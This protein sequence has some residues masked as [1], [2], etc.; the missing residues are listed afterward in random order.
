MADKTTDSTDEEVLEDEEQEEVDPAQAEDE[1]DDSTDTDT[2]DSDEEET[3]ETDED[4][5]ESDKEESEDFTK[6]FTQFKGDDPQEYLKNLEDGYAESSKEAVRL[7]RENR[8]LKANLNK[9]IATEPDLTKSD[10]G[11]GMPA[12]PVAK[13]PAL[14]W[15]EARM[16]ETNTREYNEFAEKHPEILTDPKLVEELDDE[17]AVIGAAY[18]QRHGSPISLGVGLEKAWVTLGKD[19]SDKQEQVASA[20][21]ASAG[22]SKASGGNTSKAPKSKFSE[23]QITVAMDMM[24][25]DRET[26]IKNLSAYA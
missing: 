19:T 18:F 1:T 23:Q 11:E 7:S 12:D 6:R 4:D 26:A 24:N 13:D 2:D 17:L 22:Q 15:A 14:A 20:A 16:K 9:L 21:K 3:D 10:S 25:V 5:E 8:E